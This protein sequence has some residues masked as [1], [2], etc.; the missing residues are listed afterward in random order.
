MSIPS[1]FIPKTLLAKFYPFFIGHEKCTD[2]DAKLA[3]LAVEKAFESRESL[4]QQSIRTYIFEAKSLT[5]R[6]K[7]SGA[8]VKTGSWI[9]KNRRCDMETTDDTHLYRVRKAEKLRKYIEAHGLQDRF[10]V[11]KKFLYYR[12]AEEMFYVVS[13]KLALSVKVAAPNEEAANYFKQEG[14]DALARLFLQR[15]KKSFAAL[16]TYKCKKIVCE[17][18]AADQ[19]LKDA[20]EELRKRNNLLRLTGDKKEFEEFIEALAVFS[21]EQKVEGLGTIAEALQKCEC[22]Y[23]RFGPTEEFQKALNHFQDAFEVAFT[24]EVGVNAFQS[25]RARSPNTVSAPLESV[26]HTSS[27]SAEGIGSLKEE[28]ALI[29]EMDALFNLEEETK[30]A[31]I[32]DQTIALLLNEELRPLKSEEAKELAEFSFLG[33]TDLSFGNIFFTEEDKVAILD[34]EPTR[35]VVKNVL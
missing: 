15:C 14:K 18:S 28:D 16:I 26:V 8:I 33:L 19:T 12:K 27:E 2:R 13:K 32:S 35:R 30:S 1:S 6:A 5:M 22:D 29:K 34:T 23:Q 10:A 3:K 9:V 31:A 17:L 21:G 25:D 20:F 24:S 7:S 4:D 11:P